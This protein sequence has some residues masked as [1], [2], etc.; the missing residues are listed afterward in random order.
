VITIIAAIAN[1]GCIGK[2]GELPW[3]LPEDL[4]RFKTLTSGNVVLMGRKT[5]DSLPD[6]FRPL[7]NRKN[8]I[9][10]SQVDFMA[11]SGTTAFHS[12]NA[13]LNA[14]KDDHVF[15]IG[16]ASIY[17]QTLE[18]AD[19]LEL[20]HIDRTINGNVFF[21]FIDHKTWKANAD[22]PRDG[23]RFVTYTRVGVTTADRSHSK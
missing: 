4:A 9:M 23:F 17:A 16:G 20:T 8:V 18:H 13:A 12:L 15:V 21:P 5:W 6:R 11:P 1:N 19:R 2:N 7:P 10:T 14:H 3:H 22:D